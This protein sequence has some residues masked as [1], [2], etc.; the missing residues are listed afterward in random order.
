MAKLS[1]LLSRY[2]SSSKKKGFVKYQDIPATERWAEYSIDLYNLKKALIGA[3]FSDKYKIMAAI[4]KAEAKV[5]YMYKHSNF[6]M[7]EALQ[8]YKKFK[9]IAQLSNNDL[10]NKVV[11]FFIAKSR[12]LFTFFLS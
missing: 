9:R 1:I 7:K 8:L 3:S 10:S 6:D 5:D 12:F 11:F 4:A 2:N